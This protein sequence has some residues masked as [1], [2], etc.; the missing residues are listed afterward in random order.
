MPLLALDGV[1]VA[2]GHL[3]LVDRAS[4]Q[5]D[6]GERVCLIGRNGAG[7]TTLLRVASGEQ[8]PDAGTRWLQPACASRGSNRTCRCPPPPRSSTSSPKAWATSA[9]W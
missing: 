2:F 9:R 1:S 8:P 3:P 6:R 7:K 5:I 4:M